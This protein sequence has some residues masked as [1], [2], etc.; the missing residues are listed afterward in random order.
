VYFCFL[1][2]LV[3]PLVLFWTSCTAY[4][5]VEISLESDLNLAGARC[6]LYIFLLGWM[7]MFCIALTNF[8]WRARPAIEN[9]KRKN[10][11][12]CAKFLRVCIYMYMCVPAIVLILFIAS[13]L[14]S[15]Y[16]YISQTSSSTDYQFLKVWK[17]LIVHQGAVSKKN[18]DSRTRM[19]GWIQYN[20]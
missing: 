12:L 4:P 17:I 9:W 19:L 16:V 14:I 10:T 18:N 11:V 13:G 6:H 3:L 15:G 20:Y 2:P 1:L 8:S 7:L 5:V